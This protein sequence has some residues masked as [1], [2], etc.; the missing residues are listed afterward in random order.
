MVRVGKG[1]ESGR[2]NGQCKGNLA[3][4]DGRKVQVTA[5]CEDMRLRN[6][7]ISLHLGGVGQTWSID[8]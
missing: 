1:E 7:K 2:R 3:E 8:M 6:N 4:K 5:G